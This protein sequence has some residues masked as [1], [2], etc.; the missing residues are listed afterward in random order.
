MQD[1]IKQQEPTEEHFTPALFSHR[2]EEVVERDRD[3]IGRRKIDEDKSTCD[4]DYL[5][6]ITIFSNI[7]ILQG[8]SFKFDNGFSNSIF[9]SVNSNI[10][11]FHFVFTALGGLQVRT[12]VKMFCY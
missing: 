4:T 12:S 7:Y 10:E 8:Y 5:S 11:R 6:L 3:D 2:T 9:A 1:D